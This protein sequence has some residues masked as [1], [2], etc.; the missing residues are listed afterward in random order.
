MKNSNDSQARNLL[1]EETSPYLLQHAANPVHWRPWGAAALAEASARDCPILLSVGYAACHWCHVMAHESFEDSTTASLMNSLYVNVKVDREERPD[2]DQIYM[3]ALASMGEQGGWPLTMFLAPDGK[4]FWGGTYFPKIQHYGRPS[5]I[6]VLHSIDHAWKTKRVD[7]DRSAQTLSAHIEHRLARTD[8][9]RANAPGVLTQL[10]GAI[11]PLMDNEKGGLR[12]APKFPNAPFLTILWC[13]WLMTGETAYRDAVVFSLRKMLMGG[14]YDHIGGGLARYSTDAEW[15]VPHFEKMLYDNALL[16]RLANWAYAETG[17][18]LFRKRIE[19]TIEWLI[20]EMRTSQGFASSL[21]ADSDGQEGI[22][23]T[24]TKPQLAKALPEK[25][26]LVDRFF[27]LG[28]VAHWEGA[29][30]IFQTENQVAA[31]LVDPITVD[32]IR[33]DLLTYREANRTRPGRDDKVLTD[34]NGLLIQ[35]LAESGRSLNRPDWIDL[36]SETFAKILDNTDGQGRLAHSVRGDK[37][38]YPAFSSD[39]A[40]MINAAVSL[41]EATGISSYLQQAETLKTTLDQWHRDEAGTGY[42]LTASDATDVIL[43]PRGDVDEAI[44]S[45]NGQIIEAI[46]RLA[47]A[48]DNFKLAEHA[49]IVADHALTRIQGQQYGQAGIIAAASIARNPTKLVIISLS[50]ATLITVANRN[51]NPYRVDLLPKTGQ[52]T[53]E[54]QLTEGI[55]V[56]TQTP[57]AWLCFNQTCLPV[58]TDPDELERALRRSP[59]T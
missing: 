24:W 47:S 12:G 10:A 36:A 48:S 2:I 59:N 39:Y 38:L 30:V 21:D 3:A 53:N 40:A 7:I 19:Q 50:D 26:D 37:R 45:A 51:P 55:F 14:I 23:Y 46:A 25:L 9:P 54:P 52:G 16:L 18:E 27:S 15:M 44:P 31:A 43:R 29:P 35:S 33:A 41:Y 1:S 49:I 42:Y 56:S 32:E 4:P 17:E 11:L 13:H 6:Q 5:F 28:T 58:I 34:W 57:G 20:R 8:T 22:F